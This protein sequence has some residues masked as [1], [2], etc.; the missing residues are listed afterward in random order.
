MRLIIIES[1]PLLKFSFYFLG[2]YLAALVSPVLSTVNQMWPP[3]TLCM[4]HMICIYQVLIATSTFSRTHRLPVDDS[5]SQCQKETHLVFG[6][7]RRRGAIKQSICLDLRAQPQSCCPWENLS[8][9]RPSALLSKKKKKN[10]KGQTIPNLLKWK[11]S[12][13]S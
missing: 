1:N 9:K 13:V 11:S 6:K 10:E 3:L 4:L 7:R 5:S 12:Q 2:A 8:L